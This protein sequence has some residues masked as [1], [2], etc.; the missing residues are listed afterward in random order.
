MSDEIIVVEAPE[1]AVVPFESVCKAWAV[2]YSIK[3]VHPLIGRVLG[4]WGLIWLIVGWLR[5]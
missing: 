4:L 1:S 3:P 5:E 2:K